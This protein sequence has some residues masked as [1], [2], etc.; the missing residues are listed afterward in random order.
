MT[1]T[2][3][4]G[5]GGEVIA[6][7]GD[8]AVLSD[9]YDE[10]GWEIY[11]QLSG[12]DPSEVGELLTLMRAHPGPVL[13]LAAGTGRIT[14]PLLAARREVVALELS[15]SMLGGLQK[16][17]EAAPSRLRDRCT[18]VHGDMRE[19]SLGR[20]F[21]VIVL[22]TS[23]VSLLDREGRQQLF[24]CV[25]EHLAPGGRFLMTTVTVE[26]NDATADDDFEIEV[27]TPS[28]SRLR[29]FEHWPLDAEART[30]V[31]MP[32]EPPAERVPVC[33]TRI[34]VL[35]PEQLRAE[36]AEAGLQVLQTFPLSSSEQRHSSHL[37][38]VAVDQ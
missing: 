20:E 25:R 12:Q 15:P 21:P 10:I 8:R 29:I 2:V 24:Q 30:V 22:G 16:Q 33:V 31:I 11:H 14:F 1:H 4:P 17:L 27:L 34:R 6:D 19:F 37:L 7:L 28:G 5:R 23:S 38:E 9:L 13:E 26:R 32:A 3:I 36:L 35:P 18:L